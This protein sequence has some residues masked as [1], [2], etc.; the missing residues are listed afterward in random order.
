MLVP[1]ASESLNAVGSDDC[2]L[3]M[4]LRWM[5]LVLLSVSASAVVLL[6]DTDSSD[7][8]CSNVHCSCGTTFR[9]GEER[10]GDLKLE[11]RSIRHSLW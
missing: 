2:A 9:G 6:E 8:V 1:Q 11:I 10:W 5:A 7:V 4:A 3:V